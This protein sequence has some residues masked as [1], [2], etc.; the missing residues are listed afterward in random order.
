MKSAIVLL[1]ITLVALGVTACGGSSNQTSSP[2]NSGSANSART[3]GGNTSAGNSSAIQMQQAPNNSVTQTA[4]AITPGE[5]DFKPAPE[6][7]E[8]GATQRP[9]GSIIEV[10]KFRNN[11]TFTEVEAVWGK[12]NERSLT[13]KLRNG[14]V[15]T[16]Q[17]ENLP[18]MEVISTQV[19]KE[20]AGIK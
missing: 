9:D 13:F 7:S 5:I 17:V 8:V 19:L 1:N 6:N 4:Q 15:I 11:P 18:N 2:A 14:Q 12:N 16:K 20:L 3:T 10:R